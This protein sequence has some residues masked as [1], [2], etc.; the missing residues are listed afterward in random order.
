MT[1]GHPIQKVEYKFIW[2]T[3]G[4]W[5]SLVARNLSTAYSHINGGFRGKETVADIQ[6]EML[7]YDTFREWWQAHFTVKDEPEKP[8][9]VPDMRKGSTKKR[10]K[11]ATKNI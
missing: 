7:E 6:R 11:P 9:A 10:K 8:P 1:Q 2:D 5:P 4:Q 3:R